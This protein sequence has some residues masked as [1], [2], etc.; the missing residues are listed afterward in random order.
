[1]DTDNDSRNCFNRWPRSRP[2]G[3][4]ELSLEQLVAHEVGLLAELLE[5]ANV[6]RGSLSPYERDLIRGTAAMAQL[7]LSDT[8]AA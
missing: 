3:T 4:A 5:A 1:M 7:L 6:G 2:A 8:L